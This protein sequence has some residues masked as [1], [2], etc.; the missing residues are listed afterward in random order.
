MFFICFDGS[1]DKRQVTK[2][3]MQ[4]EPKEGRDKQGEAQSVAYANALTTIRHA[5]GF[6]CCAR[7]QRVKDKDE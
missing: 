5:F 1:I 2:V 7:L 3:G 4:G 6:Y